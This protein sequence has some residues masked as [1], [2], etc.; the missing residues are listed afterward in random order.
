LPVF[1]LTVKLPAA[2]GNTL[3]FLSS[4]SASLLAL[5]L[6]VVIDINTALVIMCAV[7]IQL[8]GYNASLAVSEL[9]E[10]RVTAG[11]GRLVNSLTVLI[12]LVAGGWLGTTLLEPLS[13]SAE[14]EGDF[15]I[16]NAWQALFGPLLLACLC[17]LFQVSWRNFG[18]AY[19]NLCIAFVSFWGGLYVSGGRKNVGVFLSSVMVSVYAQAWARWK[20]RPQSIV[21]LPVMTLLVS[22]SIGFRG[23]ITWTSGDK[24][25]GMDQFLQM[26]VVAFLIIAG[27]LVGNFLVN[28][29]TTL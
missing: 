12:L 23:L 9:L 10:N 11:L 8:P 29:N 20:D 17:V 18:W 26:F 22:G 14:T 5:S 19:I 21:L 6:K 1:F 4:L 27:L 16:P 13:G 24:D 15:V 25:D 3:P 7:A 28:A 2:V